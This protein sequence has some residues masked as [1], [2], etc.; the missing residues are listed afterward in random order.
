MDKASKNLK[1][2]LSSGVYV[3]TIVSVLK[4]GAHPGIEI[5]NRDVPTAGCRDVAINLYVRVHCVTASLS[6][7]WIYQARPFSLDDLYLLPARG[8]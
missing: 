7:I 3:V 6:Y 4:A 2:M 8:E 5:M 1:S